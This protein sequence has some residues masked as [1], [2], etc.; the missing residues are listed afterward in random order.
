MRTIHALK[1]ARWR[2]AVLAVVLAGALGGTAQAAV[3]ELTLDPTAQ[4]SPGALHATLTGTVT[5]DPGDAPTLSGQIVATKN[6]P[7]GFG[8]AR[9]VCDGTS[10]TYAV[11][12]STGGG[13]PFPLPS[14]GVFKAGKANAQVSTSICDFMTWTCTTKYVDGEIRLVK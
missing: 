7:G 8:S 13:F 11:D 12:V 4:L 3:T 6:E 2:P 10:Q 14:S 5:C 9:T 1:A